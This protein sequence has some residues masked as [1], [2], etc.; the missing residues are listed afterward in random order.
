MASPL[1]LVEEQ[2]VSN[3]L[4]A[5]RERIDKFSVSATP[6]L[7]ARIGQIY[8]ANPQLT[9]GVVLAAAQANL[10]DDQIKNIGDQTAIT[11]TKD[12]NALQ[13]EKKKSWFQRNIYDRVKTTTQYG[14]AALDLPIQLGTNIASQVFNA[15]NNASGTSGWFA[16]TD[17]GSLLKNPDQ[18]GSGFFV[19][20]EAVAIATGSSVQRNGAWW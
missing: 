6:E 10:T 1:N 8:S 14:F 12:P 3:Q 16:S 15:G 19:G 4:R 17:L 5:E 7:A 20:G 11:L 2:I 18:A 13:P 9:G